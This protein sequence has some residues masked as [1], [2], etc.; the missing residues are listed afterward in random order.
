VSGFNINGHQL[1]TVGKFHAP[2]SPSLFYGK[3]TDIL[4]GTAHCT[5][6]FKMTGLDLHT[7]FDYK[8]ALQITNAYRLF[9]RDV[10]LKETTGGQREITPWSPAHTVG[11][12]PN[13]ITHDALLNT[14]YI[15][16]H[17]RQRESYGTRVSGVI[18]AL[19]SGT[20]EF[21]VTVTSIEFGMAISSRHAA[22]TV[23]RKNRVLPQIN[24]KVRAGGIVGATIAPVERPRPEAPASGEQDF[25]EPEQQQPEIPQRA[26]E[27]EGADGQETDA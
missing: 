9:G 18:D 4:T 26:L 10:T 22:S 3:V 25:V 15:M 7:A 11:I 16:V 2:V 5:D 13:S 14:H 8:S 17:S 6:G 27:G 21:T 19:H 20:I 24:I 23:Y 1:S 12:Q